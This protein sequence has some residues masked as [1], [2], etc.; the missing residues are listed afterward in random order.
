MRGIS[1]PSR[2]WILEVEWSQ[3]DDEREK[4]TFNVDFNVNIDGS[5]G[6]DLS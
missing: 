1:L 2:N 3:R 6:V 5:R 4:I